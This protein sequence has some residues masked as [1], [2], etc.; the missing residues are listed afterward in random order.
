LLGELTALATVV[1]LSPF[2][3]LPAV[4]L[5]VHSERPRGTGLAFIVGWLSGKAAITTIFVA[6]P[7]LLHGLDG[8][9][10][11]WTAPVRIVAG[12]AFLAAGLWYW[13]RPA[14]PAGAAPGWLDR[15]KRITPAG[16][17]AVGVALTLI[18][19]K[20][21]LMCAGAGYAIGVAHP[22]GAGTAAAVAYFTA[23]AGST[24]ALPIL[25]YL[26]WAE[27]VDRHL[28][29]I[30]DWLQRHQGTISVIL[31]ILI[32]VALLYSGVRAL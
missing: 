5:V 32:G 18:N 23:I 28:E 1:A 7:R 24:A 12:V 10:P 13:R 9:A 8:P 19:P 31:L 16:A 3:V 20:V 15:I 27:R 17:G 30:K 4:A 2:S 6:V 21:V 26:V 22:G 14:V 29:R 25:A 11:H